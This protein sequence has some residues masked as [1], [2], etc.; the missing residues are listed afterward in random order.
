MLVAGLYPASDLSGPQIQDRDSQSDSAQSLWPR[1]LLLA[2]SAALCLLHE[3]PSA[4]AGTTNVLQWSFTRTNGNVSVPAADNSGAGHP[5]TL[6]VVYIKP[7]FQPNK[8]E[9]L[10]LRI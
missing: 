9:D 10:A 6:A 1:Q 2:M 7:D 5:A 8:N 3:A 4:V